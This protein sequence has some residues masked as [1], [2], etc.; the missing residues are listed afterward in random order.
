[1]DLAKL[2]GWEAPRRTEAVTLN[3]HA[4]QP[5][6]LAGQL[7][8]LIGALPESERKSLMAAEPAIDAE[9]IDPGETFK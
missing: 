1:M 2:N 7:Q 6:Q 3:F 8:A 9:I 4:M 5:A